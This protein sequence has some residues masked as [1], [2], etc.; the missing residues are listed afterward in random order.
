[1]N[2]KKTSWRKEYDKVWQEAGI[3]DLREDI[4]AFIS[5]TIKEERD[6][7]YLEGYG[8]AHKEMIEKYNH[9]CDL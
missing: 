1:M 4:K 6:K 3:L 2:S 9:S 7:G 8:D 5:Q